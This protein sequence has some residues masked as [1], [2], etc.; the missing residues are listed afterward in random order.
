MTTI[1]GVSM[2]LKLFTVSLTSMGRSKITAKVSDP[3]AAA[4]LNQLLEE[5]ERRKR[6]EG[7]Q[8]ASDNPFEGL[9]E[10]SDEDEQRAACHDPNSR[11]LESTDQDEQRAACHDQSAQLLESPDEDKHRAAC[12]DPYD[13]LFE[14]PDKDKVS[15]VGFVVTLFL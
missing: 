8:R 14:S 12:H 4:R 3:E 11:L 13:W 6:E 1:D 9:F 5:Q 2:I 10:S 15:M 7:E